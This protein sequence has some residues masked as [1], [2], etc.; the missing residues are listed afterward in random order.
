MCNGIWMVKTFEI[1]KI[2][3]CCVTIGKYILYL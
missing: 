1:E 2:R 3:S